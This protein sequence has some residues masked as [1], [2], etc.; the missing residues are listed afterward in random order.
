MVVITSTKIKSEFLIKN[1]SSISNFLN[2]GVY[3][4]KDPEVRLIFNVCEETKCVNESIN[5]SMGPSSNK[6]AA[7]TGELVYHPLPQTD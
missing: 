1:T 6:L 4:R 5:Q 7:W 2:F 3:N